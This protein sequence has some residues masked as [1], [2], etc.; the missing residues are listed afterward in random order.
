MRSN[1]NA[2]IISSKSIYGFM[3]DCNYESENIQIIIELEDL[4][5]V[6][7]ELS[8]GTA[9]DILKKKRGKL[10]YL[11]DWIA[12][13]VNRFKGLL[14]MTDNLFWLKSNVFASKAH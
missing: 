5:D 8:S 13:V 9:A 4:D 6:L 1:F 11:K 2:I 12:E 3:I 7:I 14:I 10:L